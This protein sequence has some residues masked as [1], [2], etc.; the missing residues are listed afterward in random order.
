MYC[1]ECRRLTKVVRTTKSHPLLI[2]VR[3]RECPNCG[4][5]FYTTEY[6]DKPVTE[7]EKGVRGES[8]SEE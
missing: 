7:R 6:L 1:P 2:V 4:L 5:E 8:D 3:R